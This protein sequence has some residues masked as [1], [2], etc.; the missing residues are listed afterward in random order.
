MHLHFP[1]KQTT[2]RSFLLQNYVSKIGKR[3]KQYLQ[4]NKKFLLMRIKYYA[5]AARRIHAGCARMFSLAKIVR[6]WFV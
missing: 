1:E 3:H 6:R 2:E 4:K 5:V